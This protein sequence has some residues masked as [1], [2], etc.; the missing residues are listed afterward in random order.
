MVRGVLLPARRY[1]SNERARSSTLGAAIAS[2]AAPTG[3]ARRSK[4]MRSE[5]CAGRPPSRSIFAGQTGLVRDVAQLGQ[6]TCF[7]II[8]ELA[9]CY[10]VSLQLT[11]DRKWPNKV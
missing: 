11:R 9:L 10:P 7:G 4:Q 5:R 3:Q 8:L 6:R 2:P 1:R